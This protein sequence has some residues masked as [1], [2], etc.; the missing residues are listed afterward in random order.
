MKRIT[1]A[2]RC[3]TNLAMKQVV[4][5]RQPFLQ[6]IYNPWFVWCISFRFTV[7]VVTNR[8]IDLIVRSSDFYGF[9][10]SSNGVKSHCKLRM[11]DAS[12]NLR[13]W[14]NGLAISLTSTRKFHLAF[15]RIMKT[16]RLL[17]WKFELDQIERTSSQVHRTL[18]GRT[19][20]HQKATFHIV[21]F[22]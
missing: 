2:A 20:F 10:P 22:I 3:S 9:L 17:A 4:N 21:H 11:P 1:S 15:T 12:I 6:Y 13:R 8:P 18:F 7:T 16:M 19:L 5:L 14:P